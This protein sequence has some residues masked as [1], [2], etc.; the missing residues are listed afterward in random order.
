MIRMDA[1]TPRREVR[2][3]SRVPPKSVWASS[4]LPSGPSTTVPTAVTGPPA[5]RP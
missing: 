1:A 3:S 5:T 2:Y 4:S